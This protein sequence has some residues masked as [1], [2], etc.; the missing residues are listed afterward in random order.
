MI[1]IITFLMLM[2]VT[3]SKDPEPDEDPELVQ[4][5]AYCKLCMDILK[6][7]QTEHARGKKLDSITPMLGYLC[8]FTRKAQ[9]ACGFFI[10]LLGMV[11]PIL[12][13][14]T[15]KAACEKIRM[16]G[17]FNETNTCK[18]EEPEEKK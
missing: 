8:A 6:I 7:T 11:W 18:A 5:A 12:K 10:T 9:E 14:Q 13:D 15:P 1:S 16:C 17:W 4:M 3:A 2:V